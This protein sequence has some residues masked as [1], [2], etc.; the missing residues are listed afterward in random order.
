M[1]V[2]VII[3]VYKA[4]KFIKKA[5]E[6]CLQLSEVK[7]IILV[8]DGYKDRAKEIIQELAEK[9][10]IIRLYEHPN[11]ENRGAGASRNLGIEKATQEYIA[12]LDADDF[13]LPNRFVKDK[14]VLQHNPDAD[15]CYNAIGCFFYS[16]TAKDIFLNHFRSEITTVNPLANPTPENLFKGLSGTISN[17]GYFSLDGLTIN[18]NCLLKNKISFPISSMHEDT[19]FIIKLAYYA[20]LYPSELI[21]PVTLRGVHEENRITTNYNQEKKKQ[22]KNRFLMWDMLYKWG[23]NECI[24]K[25]ELKLFERNTSMYK[26][27]SHPNPG[28]LAL[29]RSLLSNP[30]LF[31]FPFYK[32]MMIDQFR[33][34]NFFSVFARKRK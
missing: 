14:E 31:K 10:S 4:E 1:D 29:T 25:E 19:V 7:E 18:R 3:P 24:K 5:I 12:F 8:D 13:F 11:N 34:C 28:L 26:I 22:Y 16:D 21:I 15:G 9:Y 27:L 20:K 17:F 2:S 23:K 30:K 33:K 6:S 32:K